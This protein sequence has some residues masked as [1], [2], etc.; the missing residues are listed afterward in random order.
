MVYSEMALDNF[1]TRLD[2]YRKFLDSFP[3]NIGVIY[4]SAD[5]ITK[6]CTEK[7]GEAGDYSPSSQTSLP[8]RWHARK[9]TF[10]YDEGLIVNFRDEADAVLFALRW[11]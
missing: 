8:L 4:N 9:I 1:A 5:E 10:P 3:Y 11:K 2:R 7:F 6:W